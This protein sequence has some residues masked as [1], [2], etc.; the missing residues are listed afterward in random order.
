MMAVAWLMSSLWFLVSDIAESVDS[1]EF[2]SV[3]AVER[4]FCGD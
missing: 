1:F 4:F 2:L 3:L